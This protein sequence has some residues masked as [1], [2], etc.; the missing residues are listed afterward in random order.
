MATGKRRE[1]SEYEAVTLSEEFYMDLADGLS[2]GNALTNARVS[3]GPSD[4]GLYQPTLFVRLV[5]QAARSSFHDDW[6]VKLRIP[7]VS[8]V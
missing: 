8:C 1:S 3:A 6:E 2:S 4:G 7:Q 5:V